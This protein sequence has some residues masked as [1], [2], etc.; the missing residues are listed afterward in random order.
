[1]EIDDAEQ[2]K[3]LDALRD[4][5]KL[6][7][8]SP[9]IKKVAEA[10]DTS[11]KSVTGPAYSLDVALGLAEPTFQ[12][13]IRALRILLSNK[14]ME[15]F[16]PSSN[17]LGL[18]NI[19]YVA[20]LIEY[21]KKRQA[22]KKTAGQIILFEEPEAHLH[23]Q[24]QLTLFE[25]LN[26]LPFQ[27]VVTTHSTHITAHAELKSY[28]TLTQTDSPAT[29]ATVPANS[30]TLDPNDIGDLE[31]Y[32]DATRSSLLFARKVMLVEGPAELFLIPALLKQVKNIDLDREG[33]TVV[34]I[35]GVHFSPYAKLFS[36]GGLPK[37]CAIVADGDLKPSDADAGVDYED[38]FP[39]P[40]DLD[41]LTSDFVRVF[42]NKT[43]FERA[44]A[45]SG[46]IRMFAETTKELGAPKVSAR[47][48]EIAATLAFGELSEPQ[49]TE[50]NNE[51]RARIL[52]SAKRFGKAR[53]AQVAT[54]HIEHATEVPK[55]LVDAVDWLNE[56]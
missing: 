43:T 1:M 47:L 10:I 26:V 50:L 38:E 8:A 2:E 12:A 31:R 41:A 20:I 35:F 37:R 40:P 30:P 6:I 48:F 4:A 54:R 11:L 39:E 53:F 34:A 21:F 24:L 52:A 25:A 32:L 33:I 36:E 45:F 49:K 7:S 17:G 3:L 5:N 28:V 29:T 16:D 55:Y 27:T 13:I 56:E 46:N 19:L 22:Q 51:V 14:A 23:P 15:N 44:I 9:S 42:K 18:N